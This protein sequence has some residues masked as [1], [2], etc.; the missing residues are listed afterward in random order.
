MGGIIGAIPLGAFVL[1]AAAAPAA[2]F[3]AG[4]EFG[5]KSRGERPWFATIRAARPAYARSRTCR[6]DRLMLIG[7]GR[8]AAR[9]SLACRQA[10][11][12]T[13]SPIGSISPVN[14]AAGRN[15]SS[16]LRL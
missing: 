14:S 9:H 13:H 2:V 4:W 11:S 12:S 15:S 7:T 5:T 10:V 8:P 6:S 1:G 3:N 16:A